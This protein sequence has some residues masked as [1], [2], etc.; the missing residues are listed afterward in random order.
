[1]TQ[2]ITCPECESDKVKRRGFR[3]TENRGKIQRY[4]CRDCG[5]AFVMDDGFFRMRNTPHKITAS[6]DLFY[7]G[8]ST[9]KVQE[10]LAI[11]YP[12]NASNVSVY[13]WIL[14]YSRMIRRITDKFQITAG[15]EVQV[16]EVQYHRRKT[17]KG[18]SGKEENWFIDSIDPKTKFMISSG[19]FKGR[20]Q[21]EIKQVLNNIKFKTGNQIKKITTDGL[22]SYPNAIKRVWGY[23][24]KKGCYNVAHNKSLVSDGH[25]FNYPIERL[26]NTIRERTKTMRGFHGC[27]YSAHS[28]MKG[29]EIY[30]NYVRKHQQLGKTPQEEAIPTLKLG[31]N[32][33]LDLIKLSKI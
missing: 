18:S 32:K 19:Y 24:L 7:R 10:H 22:L 6:I 20:G 25:G 28:I 16:D 3:K 30:Y 1:M 8:V 27:I 11:F 4:E 9:R 5:K 31:L 14:R 2:E 33:W 26:H 21:G 23:S 29:F 15:Q 17:H 12:H 13:N